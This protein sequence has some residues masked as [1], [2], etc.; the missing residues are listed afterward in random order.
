MSPVKS[1][2]RTFDLFWTIL[3]LI[4]LWPLFL[5]VAFC[6]KLD[7]GG[8]VFFRQERVGFNGS[9]FRIWKF[10]TMV[11]DAERLGKPLTVGPDPRM[12]RFGFWLRKLKV[13][14]LPQLL[15]VLSGE[16]SLVGPRP[17]VPRYVAFYTAE[18]R[19]VLGLAPGITDPA[20]IEYR[21]ENDLLSEANDAE[22]VYVEKIMPEKIKL[23][24]IYSGRATV[25][26]DFGVILKTLKE[27]FH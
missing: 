8:P 21:H 20:S 14:E 13:D 7:D 1:C 16:M 25:W 3:G 5:L 17:E 6:I 27:I 15:N 18:Q 22:K 4:L 11:I 10:R 23:N 24:L 9:P 12:T 26:S 2:K 19:Q